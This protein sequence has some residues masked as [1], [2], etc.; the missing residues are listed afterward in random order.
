M[1]IPYILYLFFF[2]FSTSLLAQQNYQFLGVIK[3]EDSTVISY[4]IS[5]TENEG[6]I[7]GHSI[8]DL[9][10]AHETKSLITGKFDDVKNLLQFKEKGIVYTKSTITETDFCYV[11]FIGHL[12]KINER[13]KIEGSFKGLY[14]DGE[15]CI[16]GEIE[17]GGLSK[18]TEKAKKIDR[19][20]DRN[21]FVKKKTKKRINVQ[22]TLDTLNMN[23]INKGETLNIF[24]KDQKLSLA[25]YDAGKED[26]DIINLSIN[27]EKIL[28]NY[29]VTH[30]KKIIPIIMDTEKTLI[31]VEALNAGKSP[32]NTVRIEVT[33]T[34]NF[35]RTLTN[36]SAGENANL[37]ILKKK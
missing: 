26:G 21:I 31:Q 29:V 23:I 34:Q 16:S 37:V 30:K 7:K 28:D 19:K 22:K 5:F 15:E 32:P 6:I 12:K 20:I 24:S 4:K 13:D 3:L 25:I 2:F 8:T 27:G 9:N 1:R 33:D 14:N 18:I 36:L 11:N 10:G 17:L 35:V